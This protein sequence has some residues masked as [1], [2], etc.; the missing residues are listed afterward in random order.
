MFYLFCHLELV[1]FSSAR[2]IMHESYVLFGRRYVFIYVFIY[3]F[4]YLFID[5]KLTNKPNIMHTVKLAMLVISMLI[6]VSI[7]EITC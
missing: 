5:F 4:I 7:Q 1:C 3:L 6:V 2:D